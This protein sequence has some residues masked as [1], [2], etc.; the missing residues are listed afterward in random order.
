MSA[1]VE[2]SVGELS[3]R[4]SSIENKL[5]RII[6]VEERQNNHSDDLKRAFVRIEK[7]EDRIRQLEIAAGEASVRTNGNSGAITIFISAMVSIAVGVIAF[8]VRGG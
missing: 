8:K 6:R 7:V 1:V 5:D 3:N 2:I 4:L